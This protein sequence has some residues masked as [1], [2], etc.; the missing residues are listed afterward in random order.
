[1]SVALSFMPIGNGKLAAAGK[2]GRYSIVE[3]QS[4]VVPSA[5]TGQCGFMTIS[6]RFPSKSSENSES[7]GVPRIRGNGTRGGDS[8]VGA[9]RLC[10]GNQTLPAFHQKHSFLLLI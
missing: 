9:S 2:P 1:M 5:S 3:V 4:S 6:Y 10:T 7:A 8:I